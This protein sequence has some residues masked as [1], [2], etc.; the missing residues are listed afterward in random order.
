MKNHKEEWEIAFDE[1]ELRKK[2]RETGC[3]I[4]GSPESHGINSNFTH[5]FDNGFGDEMV[6]DKDFIRNLLSQER[7][8]IAGE[9]VDKVKGKFGVDQMIALAEFLRDLQK[10]SNPQEQ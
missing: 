6:S 10:N 9:L 8:R 5:Q 7:E 4:C 3:A 1:R 2:N